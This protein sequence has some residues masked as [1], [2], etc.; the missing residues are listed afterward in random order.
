MLPQAYAQKVDACDQ[1]TLRAYNPIPGTVPLSFGHLPATDL[2]CDS[3]DCG[4][5][6]RKG[7]VL[8]PREAKE[9]YSR[10]FEETRCQWTLADLDPAEDQNIWTDKIGGDIQGQDDSLHVEDLDTVR[11]I[12]EG[13]ARLGSYRITVNKENDNGVPT[14]YTVILSKT[15]HNFLLRKALLR[16][17]GYRIPPVK[18]VPRIKINFDNKDQKEDFIKNISVNNAGSFDR[19]VLSQQKKSV[20]IQDAVIMEDQEFRLNLS[21]GY[22]SADIFEGKRIYDSLLIPYALVEIPESINMLDWTVGRVYSDNVALK[23]PHAKEYNCSRD[24]AIWMVRRIMQLSEKDWQ[25]IV[26]EAKLPP[27][28]AV[29][30]LEKLKSRRNHLGHLFG[31]ENKNL[32]VDSKISNHDDLEDGKLTKEFYDGYARRFKIPDPE[33]PLSYSEMVSMFKSKAIT[34]GLELLIGAFNSSKL[35]GTD[36]GSKVGDLQTNFVE[37]LAENTATSLVGGGSN[38]TPV[39][40]YIFP[41]VRGNIILN[42]EIV[43]GHY[44]GTDNMIQLV[45]TVGASISVGA[46]GG[47]LGVFTETGSALPQGGRMLMPVDLTANAKVFYNRTYAHV[48]PITSVQKALK[49]PFRNMFVP[50]L[51]RKY[52]HVFDKINTNEYMEMTPE[53]RQKE[54]DG[55]MDL[56][57]DNLEVGESIIITDSLGGSLTAGAG[58]SLYNVAKI[59]GHVKPSS[60]VMSRLHIYRASQDEVHIYKDLGNVNAVELALGVDVYIPVVKLTFKGALGR[61]RTK[62]YKLNIGA[63]SKDGTY[64]TENIH[65]ED[66]LRGLRRVLLSGSLATIDQHIKPWV[67]VHKFREKNTKFGIFVWRWNWLDTQDYITITNPKGSKKEMYRRYMGRTGGRDFESYVGDLVDLIISKIFNS[68]FT[69]RSF[70]EGNPG[71]TFMGKAKNRVITFEGMINEDQKIEKPY[72]KLSRIWN[73]WQIKKK[74]AKNILKE[75]KQRYGFRFF[76]DEVLAQTKKLF[77]YNINVNFFIYDKGLN[78]ALRIPEERAKYI[79][80]HYQSRDT[81]NYSGDDRLTRSGYYH[82]ISY[83]K[84]YLKYLKRNDQRRMAKYMIKLV[85]ITEERLKMRGIAQIFGGGNNL[86]AIARI[87][88]FRVGDENGDKRLISSSFGRIGT[89]DLD[90]PIDRLKKFIGMTYGEF[91]MSW[92]MG[93]VI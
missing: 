8:S 20:V 59:K 11:F 93:R 86:F 4:P 67:V 38:S 84:K 63:K 55:M 40:G 17:L 60:I 30:L 88:G 6:I 10:R 70:N 25:E 29:L 19:W 71:F 51:K 34:K 56:L 35:M 2:K 79:W 87:D 14:Q 3:N 92:L 73:G 81:T 58:V 18:Y 54:M 62:F 69:V 13:W 78:Y 66:N 44:L 68:P 27:S 23:F 57:N 41:T 50:Y 75:I 52:G 65:R 83:R 32:P 12:S 33:S 42:R 21:K 72:I 82:F 46:F 77:L 49:Y 16:K 36:I 22:L 76:E 7:D 24:D 53:A 47:L 39:E 80:T 91:Y 26:D 74:K 45:D 90:G 5:G 89:E 43:A 85:R 31:V 37:K 28:V 61:G 1:L 64:V 15:V 48:K 9:Y